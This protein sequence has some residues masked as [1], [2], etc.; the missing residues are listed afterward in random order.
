MDNYTLKLVDAR[1]FDR[2][3]QDPVDATTMAQAAAI[4]E[5]I[6]NNGEAG[7]RQAISTYENRKNDPLIIEK[8]ELEAAFNRL[9]LDVQQLLKR[10]QER[11]AAFAMEQRAC[12]TN[13][14]MA[15]P[16]GRAGHDLSLIHI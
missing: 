8:R 6:K 16:G 11:I 10:T 13:L 4:I 7:L 5:D 14:D 15:I 3:R 1:A 9:D 2:P 12:L